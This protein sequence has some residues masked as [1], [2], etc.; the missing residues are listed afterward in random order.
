MTTTAVF[1]TGVGD[2]T[3]VPPSFRGHDTEDTK[4]WLTRFEKYASFRDMIDNDRLRLVAV[5]LRDTASEWWDNLDHTT[6][7]DWGLFKTAFK[8]RFKDAGIMKWKKTSDLWS[9][10][11]SPTERVNDYVAAV[12]KLARALGVAG[13][14]EQYAVQ[15]GLRPQIL[16]SVI[17]SRPTT[18]EDVLEAA[19]VAKA[20]Q[21]VIDQA[22]TPTTTDVDRMIGELAASRI[23]AEAN[24]QEIRKVTDQLAKQPQPVGNISPSLSSQR[25][26]SPTRR[27]VTFAD[28]VSQRT[29]RQSSPSSRGQFINYQRQRGSSTGLMPAMLCGNC[30]GNHQFGRQFCRALNVQCYNCQKFGYIARCCRGTRRGIKGVSNWVPPPRRAIEWKSWAGVSP[31]QKGENPPQNA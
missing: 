26:Q 2:A 6:K 22:A 29:Y 30:E 20:P 3:F 21:A 11:Q 18:L 25:G 19:K 9:R 10:V 7:G 12:R 23:V 8:T 1:V 27:R 24:N 14:Q 13:A 17:K 31:I 15:R 28:D 16:E 4:D 5:L